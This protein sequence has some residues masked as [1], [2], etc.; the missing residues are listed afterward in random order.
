[1]F[2]IAHGCVAIALEL[3]QNMDH[4]FEPPVLSATACRLLQNPVRTFESVPERRA[5]VSS[6]KMDLKL[7]DSPTCAEGTQWR[8]VSRKRRG[9]LKF[10]NR[11]SCTRVR[12]E[13]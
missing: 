6:A 12:R 3:L 11:A 4:S 1:M 10:A 7:H 13:C 9:R 5:D 2:C 8:A